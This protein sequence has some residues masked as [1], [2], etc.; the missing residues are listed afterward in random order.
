MATTA[1]KDLAY[2]MGLPYTYTLIPQ[3]AGVFIRV[4]ELPGC[5]S[6]GDT[7]DE[8]MVRIREAMEGW[9]ETSLAEGIPVP[10]PEEEF[11]GKILARV[12]RE[13]HRALIH[14]AKAEGVSL[15]LYVAS[16]LARAVGEKTKP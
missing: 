5:R 7:A 10:E 8:A 2:Y 3:P 16:A 1:T 11:S 15:N 6:G 12:P 4:N 13:I 14:R 9:I